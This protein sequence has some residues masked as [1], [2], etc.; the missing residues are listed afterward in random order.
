M[1]TI[2]QSHFPF[3][4]F[5]SMSLM[6]L[7]LAACQTSDIPD[8][9]GDSSVSIPYDPYNYDPQKLDEEA[10]AHC[11]AYGLLARFDDETIDDQSVR[12]RY[13]HYTCV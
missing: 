9:R 13:R 12:W 2:F 10:Q 4:R 1:K 7:S 5:V 11:D 6:I 3:V 8:P